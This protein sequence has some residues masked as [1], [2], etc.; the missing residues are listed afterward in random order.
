MTV[1]TAGVYASIAAGSVALLILWS[2]NSQ[3]Q[4]PGSD[5]QPIMICVGADGAPRRAQRPLRIRRDA[6]AHRRNG[7]GA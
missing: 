1:N 5:A 3:P 7:F 4:A 2:A 6:S